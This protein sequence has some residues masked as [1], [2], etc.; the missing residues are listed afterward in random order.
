[1]FRKSIS[2]L[3]LSSSL[4]LALALASSLSGGAARAQIPENT[5]TPFA[6]ASSLDLECRRAAGPPP[7]PAVLVRQLNPV[8]QPQIPPQQAVLGPL[9]EVCVPVAKNGQLPPPN[10]L[11]INRWVDAACYE[12]EAPPINVEVKLS[13]LNPQLTDLPDETVKIVK[14]AQVCLPVMKNHVE[15]PPAIK[16]AV[17]HFDFACYEL[18]EPTQDPDRTLQLSHLNPVIQQMNLPNRLVEMKRAH[19]LC[20]PI[21]K[22]NQQVPPG[23]RA[24]VEWVDFLKYRVVPTVPPPPL[25]LWLGHLNPLYA[26]VDPFFTVLQPDRLRLM[27]P[28]AKDGHIPP[29]G[30]ND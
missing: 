12:A 30:P 13:H 17:A 15:P 7:A 23:I 29:G 25:P 6:L 3:S 21:A 18:E 28:V 10:A 5:P 4:S 1:M 8:L 16:Q 27:V 11:A 2:S 24:L 26:E 19:H 20:V 9:D 14:L 22:N